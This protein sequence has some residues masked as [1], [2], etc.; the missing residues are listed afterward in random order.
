MPD[1]RAP[2]AGDFR[3]Y[4][5]NALDVLAGLL[6]EELR[7]PAP[8]QSL[9]APDTILIPQV[10]MRRWLQATLA[11]RHGIAANLEFLT[12]GEFVAR[13]LKANPGD[14]PASGDVLDAQLVVGGHHHGL[15]VR[16]EVVAAHGGDVRLRVRGPGT[17]RVRVA[18]RVGL[19]RG[20][21]AAVGVAFA[22]D[23]VHGGTLDL[24]VA[25]AD[26]RL[27]VRGG[28]VRVVRQGVALALKLGDGGLQLRDG[29]ADVRQ[30]DDVGFGRLRQLSELGQ[31]IAGPLVFREVVTED[32][33]DAASQRDI[34]GLHLHTSCRSEGLDNRQ[35]RIRGQHRRFVGVGIDNLGHW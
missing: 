16:P 3:L 2:S 28:V 24:V 14:A 15:L 32:G 33:D 9:L 8:G 31:R 25:G 4:H 13:A 29:R 11:A 20:R 6:A 21:R 5:S 26:V 27:L 10:A 17:H 35:E 22:Q 30:L 34:A 1:A 12:P 18:A 19:H 7:T 23:R